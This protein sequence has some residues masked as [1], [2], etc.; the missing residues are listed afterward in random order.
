MEK[1]YLEFREYIRKK[2]EMRKARREQKRNSLGDD[3]DEEEENEADMEDEEMTRMFEVCDMSTIRWNEEANFAFACEFPGNN[4]ARVHING[5]K[6]GE[7][8][9]RRRECT[10]YTW[11]KH[12]NGT[13]WLKS[14]PV[15]RADAVRT[16]DLSMICGI[17]NLN[18]KLSN[19]QKSKLVFYYL[20]Y[21]PF[22]DFL[23]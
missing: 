14:G 16:H 17:T 22:L 4:V 21:F 5:E 3:Y 15:S 23:F 1:S 7:T 18:F 11:T 20:L 10:H 19:C 8:C 13:C 2:S 6:C 12:D 9:D